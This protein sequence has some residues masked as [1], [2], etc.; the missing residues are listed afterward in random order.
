MA[1]TCKAVGEYGQRLVSIFQAT[2]LILGHGQIVFA[3]RCEI[4]TIQTLEDDL[5]YQ[6]SCTASVFR[7]LGVKDRVKEFR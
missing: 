4:T 3:E 5:W 1:W 7:L 6:R 2:K